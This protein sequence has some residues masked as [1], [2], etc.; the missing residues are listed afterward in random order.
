[1]KKKQKQLGHKIATAV[2]SAGGIARAKQLRRRKDKMVNG[3]AQHYAAITN[4]TDIKF[5]LALV[6]LAR[7]T[8]LA[9]RAYE[10]LKNRHSLLNDKGELCESND[11][12]RRLA[13]GQV[14][15]LDMLGLTPRA[16]REMRSWA[17]K[18]LD[19]VGQLART[20]TVNGEAEHTAEH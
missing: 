6:S 15:M 18:E 1:M 8:L 19:L 7:I 16:A 20:V 14:Q 10:V 4:L 11:S 12:F 3:V 17:E 9:E 13:L 5:R 2:H